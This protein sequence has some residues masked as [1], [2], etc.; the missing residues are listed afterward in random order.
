MF[1]VLQSE[2]SCPLLIERLKIAARDGAMLSAQV[3]STRFGMSSGPEAF[4]GF[5][6]LSSLATPLVEMMR[7]SR[8]GKGLPFI[9]GGV[10][11]SDF[12]NTD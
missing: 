1:A 7:S 3:L 9:V 10:R 2:G 11:Q 4:D 5:K 8:V 6:F 12:V